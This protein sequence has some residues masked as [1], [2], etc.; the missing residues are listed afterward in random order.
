MDRAEV[1]RAGLYDPA[2]PGAAQRLELLEHLASEGIT[3]DE[4]VEA[5]RANRLTISAAERLFRGGRAWRKHP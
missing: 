4:M 5:D 2:A 1:I 3:I